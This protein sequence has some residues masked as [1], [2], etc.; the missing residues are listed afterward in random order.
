ML[1][2]LLALAVGGIIGWI[3]SVVMRT[4]RQQA[5][6]FNVVVGLFGAFLG[7]FVLGPV[8]GGGNLLENRFDPM[9]LVVAFLGA[10]A[11]LTI[12]ALFRRRR[13]RRGRDVPGDQ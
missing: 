6:V 8:M 7:G 1:N 10:I 2:L 13:M 4:D 12:V 3:A 11:L 5:K 9:S